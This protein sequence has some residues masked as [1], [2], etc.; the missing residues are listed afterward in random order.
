MIPDETIQAWKE[1]RHPGPQKG[2]GWP[3]TYVNWKCRCIPCTKANGAAHIARSAARSAARR[4][5]IPLETL[6]AE[7]KKL[8]DHS[9]W[10]IAQRAE[11]RSDQHPVCPTCRSLGGALGA[12]TRRI[13][14]YDRLIRERSRPRKAA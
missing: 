11:H 14:A 7:R 13:N 5:S 10:L 1:G 2:H 4:A 3:S 12:T 8:V 6:R 9:R